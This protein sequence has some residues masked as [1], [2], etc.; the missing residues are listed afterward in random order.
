MAFAEC[1]PDRKHHAKG[2]CKECYT[3]KWRKENA[4]YIRQYD[5]A[6]GRKER[7]KCRKE[8]RYKKTKEWN[9]AHPRYK[10]E[11]YAKN[12]DKARKYYSKWSK[13]YRKQHGDLVREQEMRNKYG[14]SAKQIKEMFNSQANRC[15]I[16]GTDKDFGGR[17]D[18]P[19]IDHDHADG[20]VRGLLCSH[21]NLVL[22]HAKD[23]VE[24]LLKA[25]AYLSRFEV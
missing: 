19:H 22:G 1:H 9:K 16:C 24:I 25:A 6:P 18:K 10:K 17:W 5:K 15:A 12:I 14:L 20:R 23:N 8:Y 3:S 4:E 11:W 2:L 13:N 21:C 7:W